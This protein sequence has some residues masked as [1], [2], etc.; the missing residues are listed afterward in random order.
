MKTWSVSGAVVASTYIGEF[1][2]ETWEEAI[3]LAGRKADVTLC[4]HC[5]DNIIDPEIEWLWAEDQETG[6][7]FSE[8]PKDET[9]K[10]KNR[11]KELEKKINNLNNILYNRNI[12]MFL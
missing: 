6:E 4:H 3:K 5:S 9:E 7:T 8:K 1:E 2:A 10:L 12:E 11:I